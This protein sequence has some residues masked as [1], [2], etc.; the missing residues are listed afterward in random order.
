LAKTPKKKQTPILDPPRC[1]VCGTSV[2]LYPPGWTNCPACGR[3]VCRQCWEEA[4]DTKNFDSTK[5]SHKDGSRG[6][7]VAPIGERVKPSL[8]PDWTS[9]LIRGALAALGVLVLWLLYQIFS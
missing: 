4:W 7:A 2:T 5:C 8:I 6:P 9:Y 3:P 1:G